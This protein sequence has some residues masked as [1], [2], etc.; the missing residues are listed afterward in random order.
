MKVTMTDEMKKRPKQL[1]IEIPDNW[2]KEIKQRALDYNMS[3]KDWV[4]DAIIQKVKKEKER[5]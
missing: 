3:I 4:L 5:E 2:H 1:A